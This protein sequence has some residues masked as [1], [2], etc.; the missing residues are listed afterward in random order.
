M[1]GEEEEEPAEPGRCRIRSFWKP[2]PPLENLHIP[3][4]TLA[5]PGRGGLLLDT[6]QGRGRALR[7]GRP[8]PGRLDRGGRDREGDRWGVLRAISV[9]LVVG[10]KFP[11]ILD[12]WGGVWGCW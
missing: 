7:G 4:A 2:L 9:K 1:G 8:D 3:V 6:E 5:R 10:A 12:G 11:P